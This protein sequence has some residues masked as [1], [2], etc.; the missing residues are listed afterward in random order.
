VSKKKS[1]NSSDAIGLSEVTSLPLPYEDRIERTIFAQFG[2]Q[3]VA[4]LK[5]DKKLRFWITGILP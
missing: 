1:I 3:S 2:Q 4:G 5:S